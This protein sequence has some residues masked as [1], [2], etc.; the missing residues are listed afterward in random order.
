MDFKNIDYQKLNEL[1]RFVYDRM[2]YFFNSEKL[3]KEFNEFS[4]NEQKEKQEKEQEKEGQECDLSKSE[5]GPI[6]I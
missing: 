1:D 2:P 3:N 5:I 4:E 6:K